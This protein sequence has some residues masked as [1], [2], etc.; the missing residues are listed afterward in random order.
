[1]SDELRYERIGAYENTLY[2]GV[3][4][5]LD[6]LRAA[7]LSLSGSVLA[8]DLPVEQARYL[9]D[10]LAETAARVALPDGV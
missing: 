9:A 7:G 4:E 1:M 10:R 5:M 3:I 6:A 8:V 2:D